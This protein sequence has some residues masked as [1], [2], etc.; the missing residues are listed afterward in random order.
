[1]IKR[2][3]KT[4]PSLFAYLQMHSIL[5][6]ILFFLENKFKL[7]VC[8]TRRKSGNKIIMTMQLKWPPISGGQ[9]EIKGH[10]LAS[11]A[12]QKRRYFQHL[13]AANSY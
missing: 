1:L 6:S 2:E 9:M 10:K 8:G 12:K 4:T 11:F 13:V 7:E 3:E 5:F